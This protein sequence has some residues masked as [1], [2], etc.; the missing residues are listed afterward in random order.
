M[1][2]SFASSWKRSVQRRKQRKYAYN[3]P[4]HTKGKFLAVHLSK[5]LRDQ[6][7][8][9][10]I[11]VRKGDTVKILRGNHKGVEG[12]VEAVDV[13]R[14]RV[15]IA[16]VERAKTEGSTSKLQFHPSSLVITA[17][18]LNDK[19]RKEKLEKKKE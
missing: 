14:T 17:L 5:E 7:K 15:T 12:K 1:K 8:T 11:R 13:K 6:Y 3:A 16:K 18:D 4:D 19:K 9:R 10:S 2:S